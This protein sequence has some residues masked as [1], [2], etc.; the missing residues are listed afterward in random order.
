MKRTISLLTAGLAASFAVACGGGGEEVEEFPT[1]SLAWSEYPSWSVFGV[2][3]ELG[4]IDGKAGE[5][6][7]I[8]AKWKVDIE[9]KEADYDGCITN[10]G[11]GTADAACLTNMDSLA[12]SL[13]LQAVAIL[14]TSTSVGA[15]ALLTVGIDDVKE[16]KGKDVL[17]FEGTVSEYTFVRNLQ[18][19]GENEE[20]YK[21][22][23]KDPATAAVGMQQGKPGYEAIVVWN[24][25]VLDTLN[26][27][28]DAKVLFDSKSIPGEIIDMVVMSA[29]S[30]AKPGGDR[31]ACAVI[32]TFYQFCRKIEDP[33][34]REEYLVALGE[35][36]SD[37]DAAS[38][39]KVL[40]MTEFYD[41]SDEG[42]LL[43]ES[44]ELVETMRKVN[45]FC[46]DHGIVGEAP[47]VGYGEWSQDNLGFD[48]SY[49]K[50]VREQ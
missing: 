27:V 44:D 36:F 4:M 14:P 30:L 43:F 38:M 33:S 7:P 18:I 21:F 28:K 10:F 16:L 24:P 11:A 13:G 19:L 1:F 48:A 39:E 22:V 40:E 49:I 25:F 46:V 6:G 42:I 37:L 5:M 45:E 41:T 26:K 29:D 34:S 31:F 8:E 3:D 35:K 9:L 32:D 12:P 47:K 17:G 2:A 23:M 50:R 20:D 15:D